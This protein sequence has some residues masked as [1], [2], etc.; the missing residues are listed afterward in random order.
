M[1]AAKGNQFWKLR[2]EH[3]RKK[4]FETPELL[5]EA[6]VNYFQWVDENP[7]ETVEK[8][9]SSKD[10]VTKT[11]ILQR[12]YTKAGFYRFIGCSDKWLTNFKKSADNDFL[13]VIE[14]IE[15]IIEE[16]QFSG[17]AIGIFKE[18]II[19]RRLGLSDKTE[20]DA[21]VNNNVKGSID[22]SQ[23]VLDKADSKKD[24]ES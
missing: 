15:A 4:L 3:G 20:I 13:T 14:E 2:S 24:A 8:T 5:Q 17:A 18:N 6:A 19:S 12:P 1:G 22:V 9:E 23:W 21:D 7:I 16:N 11:K 10:F